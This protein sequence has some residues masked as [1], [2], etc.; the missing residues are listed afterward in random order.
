MAQDGGN[1]KVAAWLGRQNWMSH[2]AWERVF[3]IDFR[4]LSAFRIFLGITLLVDLVLRSRD[5]TLFY[6]EDGLLPVSILREQYNAR[7]HWSVHTLHGAA[8]YQAVLFVL[9]ALSALALTLGFRTRWATIASWFFCASLHSRNPLI[10]NSGDVLLL[11]LLFWSMFLP[12]GRRWAL[13]A[14]GKPAAVGRHLSAAGAALLVQ[15]CLM[16]LFAG[17]NKMNPAWLGGEALKNTFGFQLYARP[18]A[19][20]ILDLDWLLHLGS[21]TT[22]FLQIIFAL[23]CFS[24]WR[25]QMF[26]YGVIVIV[27]GFHLSIEISLTTGLF[28]YVSFVAWIPFLGSGFWNWCQARLPARLSPSGEQ[29]APGDDPPLRYQWDHWVLLGLLGC[30]VLYNFDRWQS[31]N[32]RRAFL[33]RPAR[34]LM[35]VTRLAQEWKMFSVPVGQEG[36]FA[37]TGTTRDGRSIDLLAQQADP[38]GL[39]RSKP[40]YPYRAF[41]SHRLRKYFNSLLRARKKAHRP[42]HL[43]RALAHQW[44]RKHP[45]ADEAITQVEIEFLV[46][47]PGE[48]RLGRAFHH[49]EDFSK[50]AREGPGKPVPAN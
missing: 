29:P 44:E 18:A 24:P 10:L 38:L 3:G 5:I 34:A 21:V 7:G 17:L 48:S 42:D 15:V 37:V 47:L 33:P 13:D 39:N 25:T 14:R 8:A 45:G 12:L 4:A 6:S 1:S 19:Y 35:S 41:S 16:Y 50:P 46:A 20:P 22:P 9:A 23:V 43:A 26:R 36:W 40:D 11:M 27:I 49:V 30:V 32:D 28:A 31:R 2:P